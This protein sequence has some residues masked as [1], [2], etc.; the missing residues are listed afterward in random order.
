VHNNTR[1]EQKQ[2]MENEDFTLTAVEI[3]PFL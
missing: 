2:R 1:A 3:E